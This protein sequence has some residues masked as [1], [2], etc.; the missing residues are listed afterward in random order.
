M[1][2]RAIARAVAD[3]YK[4]G[5][6]HDAIRNRMLRAGA[7]TIFALDVGQ[8]LQA[9][10]HEGEIAADQ[11]GREFPI[12]SQLCRVE[13]VVGVTRHIG[14]ITHRVARDRQ[15]SQGRNQTIHV[16]ERRPRL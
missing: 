8:V 15:N 14:V 16:A 7:V 2:L 9:R 5:I 12:I 1:A 6:S 11:I 3:G 10:R 4:V 13:S